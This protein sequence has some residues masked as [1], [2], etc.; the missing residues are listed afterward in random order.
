MSTRAKNAPRQT[1]IASLNPSSFLSRSE[2]GLLE[3][4]GLSSSEVS[5]AI[6]GTTSA[7]LLPALEVNVSEMPLTLTARLVVSTH[8][9]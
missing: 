7:V 2:D 4:S 3:S 6:S 1:A 5:H 9:W 8:A